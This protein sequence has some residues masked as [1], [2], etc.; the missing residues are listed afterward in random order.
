MQAISELGAAM[1][2]WSATH[3]PW[4]ELSRYAF[5][6][7]RCYE[8]LSFRQFP[9]RTWYAI[10][11]FL[12]REWWSRAWISPE[13]TLAHRLKFLC[14]KHQF[15]IDD[16]LYVCIFLHGSGWHIH[17]LGYAATHGSMG[18]I[19]AQCLYLAAMRKLARPSLGTSISVFGPAMDKSIQAIFDDDAEALVLLVT[20]VKVFKTTDARDKALVP[21][22]LYRYSKKHAEHTSIPIEY[23]SDV[24]SLY[25]QLSA[26]LLHTSNSLVLLS[27][28]E[29]ASMRQQP[30]LPSWCPD[31]TVSVFHPP[32]G[33]IL[34]TGYDA[35]RSRQKY[36]S[37][38]M[39]TRILTLEGL[40]LEEISAMHPSLFSGSTAKSLIEICLT[41][42][43]TY[44]TNG[45]DR[46]EALWRTIIADRLSGTSPAPDVAAS[47]F[48]G[49][50][51][52]LIAGGIFGY[53]FKSSLEPKEDWSEWSCFDEVHDSSS[54][55][56]QVVP[57]VAELSSYVERYRELLVAGESSLPEM[58][59]LQAAQDVFGL[60]LTMAGDRAYF[61]TASGLLGLV[62]P[63]SREG[64]QVWF[65]SGA[66]LPF[67]LRPEA[68]GIHYT[69]VGEAY[70]NGYMRGE[71][72]GVTAES[73]FQKVMIR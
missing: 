59:Q 56:S 15:D 62:P 30:D 2:V 53:N 7:K 25:T 42:P 22:T 39:D 8:A 27:Q 46:T 32:L 41:L 38:D 3:D 17:L 10:A 1:R 71:I 34:L 26:Y 5:K 18:A 66:K 40:F 43:T 21:L 58:R 12:G 52:Y 13:V 73:E 9:L 24:S 20:R 11:I 28:V 31:Y 19:G 29:D 37:I 16:L 64:D 50:L 60:A 69:L 68:D 35:L 72:L 49:W 44:R 67:V 47:Y 14:G 23:A 55:A 65:F 57:N 6:D 63:S 70:V 45:Q 61:T 54:A 33:D 4:I 48:K 36:C 51:Q